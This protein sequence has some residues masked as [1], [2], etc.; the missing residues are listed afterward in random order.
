[1][2]NAYFPLEPGTRWI[3][4]EVEN[5]AVHRVVDTATGVTKKVADGVTAVVVRDT[6][7][8]DGE[9]VEDTF[10]WYAQDSDGTVWYLGEDTAEYEHG[11]VA[12]REGA[13]EAGVDGA[14][15][16]VIM[17]A[18]PAVGQ[19]Y[20][21]EY[22]RGEAEDNG[23]VL[24]LSEM[25]DVAAGH[26]DDLVLIK[27]TSGIETDVLEYKLYAEGVGTV[28][29]LGVSGDIGREEL[30]RTTTV[31]AA[32]ARAAGMTPLGEPYE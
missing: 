8:E 4:R 31:P 14:Q 22:L 28:L 9:V 25:A 12:S 5:G 23:A 10:D 30:V 3:Y 1:V 16:G 19:S 11:K 21:E 6:V 13:W 20:R 2:D 17:P 32:Q 7:S 15:A 18:D 27:D 26:Y 24:S 29:S